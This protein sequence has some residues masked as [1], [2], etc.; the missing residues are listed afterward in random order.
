MAVLSVE[1]TTPGSGYTEPPTI[2]FS[3]ADIDLSG[4]SNPASGTHAAAAA[5]LD[6]DLPENVDPAEVTVYPLSLELNEG[7]SGTYSIVLSEAP[8]DTVVISAVVDPLS[9]VVVEPP[10]VTFTTTDW[11]VPLTL[12]VTANPDDDTEPDPAT[13]IA[14]VPSGGG[15]ENVDVP[16][17]TVT[18]IEI[19]EPVIVAVAVASIVLAAQDVGT[20][21]TECPQVTIGAPDAPN[22]TTATATAVCATHFESYS[23]DDVGSAY[24]N[25]ELQA[26][27][28]NGWTTHTGAFATARYG[29][30]H[31]REPGTTWKV[32]EN[33]SRG[34]KSMYSENVGAPYVYRLD[35][36]SDEHWFVLENRSSGTPR[37]PRV[38]RVH[39]GPLSWGGTTPDLNVEI[40]QS[41]VDL[42][43]RAEVLHDFEFGQWQ[44][45]EDSMAMEYDDRFSDYYA[46]VTIANGAASDR[47]SGYYEFSYELR[48]E[49]VPHLEA[50]TVE[51]LA[52][53]DH[54]WG[55]IIPVGGGKV[56]GYFEAN[57]YDWPFG[58][59]DRD[60]FFFHV[61]EG[62]DFDAV[63]WMESDHED[64]FN[65]TWGSIA[66]RKDGPLE[67][68]EDSY[69][70][71]LINDV[72]FDP[73]NPNTTL[74]RYRLRAGETYKLSMWSSWP[75]TRYDLHV[76][77]VNEPGSDTATA[78]D[79]SITDNS[80]RVR[81]GNIST[82]DDVDYFR[83]VLD[84]ETNVVIRAWG[85]DQDPTAKVN[86]DLNG[87]AELIVHGDL[88][89]S[90]G[91][92]YDTYVGRDR[93][94][95][96]FRGQFAS[97][98][99]DG[100][101]IFETLSAGTYYVQVRGDGSTIGPYTIAVDRHERYPD[102]YK[103][104]AGTQATGVRDY[105]WDCQFGLKNREFPGEDINV[106][107]VWS[108]HDG[109]GVKVLVADT[110]MDINHEDLRDNILVDRNKSYGF[111]GAQIEMKSP[112]EY[113]HGTTVAGVIAARDNE[114]GIRGIAPRAN[115]ISYN[116]LQSASDDNIV[117]ALTDGYD[118]IAVANHSWGSWKSLYAVATTTSA[119][120]GLTHSLNNSYFVDGSPLGTVH[121]KAAGNEYYQQA[122]S[123][124]EEFHSHYGWVVVC[125][126]SDQGTKAWFSEHGS[127]L[128][129]CAPSER[130][131]SMNFK[132][133]ATPR[134]PEDG[135]EQFF[136]RYATPSTNSFNTYK[137]FSGTSV[138]T[139][140]VSGVAALIRDANPN[141]TW[142]D[143]KMILAAT[144]RVNDPIIADERSRWWTHYGYRVPVRDKAN[145]ET[146]AP[147]VKWSGAGRKFG[148]LG[149]DSGSHYRFSH[150]YGFG[151]VDAQ[152]AVEL[153]Q[154]WPGLPEFVEAQYRSEDPPIRINDLGKTHT[155]V[156]GVTSTDRGSS[157]VVASADQ[158]DFIEW[159]AVKAEF[160]SDNFRDLRV[161]LRSPSG[162]ESL[163]SH[164]FDECWDAYGD[165]GSPHSAY[166]D[167][168]GDYGPG[169]DGNR[170]SQDGCQAVPGGT[171]VHNRT[172][173]LG[174]A[175]HL[176]E[177]PCNQIESPN[178][179]CEWTLI[180]SDEEEYGQ[181]TELN[182]WSMMFYGH[183]SGE[184]DNTAIDPPNGDPGD[185]GEGDDGDD[186]DGDDSDDD[187]STDSDGMSGTCVAD[188]TTLCLQ[189]NR[190]KANVLF[191]ATR[192]AFPQRAQL[193]GW[194][195]GS[196][197][198]Y[199]PGVSAFFEDP[200]VD[201]D[202]LSVV[203]KLLDGCDMTG[204]MWFTTAGSVRYR[205]HV[206]LVDTVS[207]EQ[208]TTEN[209]WAQVSNAHVDLGAFAEACASSAGFPA[210]AGARMAKPQGVAMAATA[211]SAG[212]SLHDDKFTV[213]ASYRMGAAIS[214]GA[215]GDA[216]RSTKNSALFRFMGDESFDLLVN[217]VNHCAM[218]KR[219]RVVIAGATIN[220]FSI[221]ITHNESGK[222]REYTRSG[223]LAVWED[224][225]GFM[226]PRSG[227]LNGTRVEGL[228]S[229]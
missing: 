131:E 208:I 119:M 79:L 165:A 227:F 41:P 139:P 97:H 221:T 143:V 169:R 74:L 140:H 25:I 219:Y 50:T 186:S 167:P 61:P 217:V 116:V 83:L 67:E 108:S 63:V 57:Y 45:L 49:H 73:R 187:G 40:W 26:L 118:D 154:V 222:R 192:N 100:F 13:E 78:V 33:G 181:H 91:S 94:T 138:A 124:L 10:S 214:G 20:L 56:E 210:K 102:F 65:G 141:L 170:P 75:P 218:S 5:Y 215:T 220:D 177:S 104:C 195:Q 207:G 178:A 58:F 76:H 153:A 200:F 114:I 190:F 132:D 158:V 34:A 171:S 188:D 189:N 89:N 106:E 21:Y 130:E 99:A 96:Q 201:T 64:G 84:Q 85:G 121:V 223:E 110:G 69:H 120:N 82:V 31:N 72:S 155:D 126:V 37:A 4:A 111:R 147:W 172:L 115:L 101:T 224:R 42:G 44:L 184:D 39:S 12:S 19:D 32:D 81:G 87:E 183:Q 193:A 9:D 174:S 14:H 66:I 197:V 205:Y 209:P 88:R 35:D 7:A 228:C 30:P 134:R 164:P 216:E 122:Y 173:S 150:R 28:A 196:G 137:N 3:G 18:I 123:T 11:D 142:R 151:V 213:T 211:G 145:P 185:E 133:W 161:V 103:D 199:L 46:R 206:I 125:A 17:L 43:D 204:G 51:V 93:F 60:P 36:A 182:A 162:T 191:Y 68:N 24:Y 80:Q 202:D 16:P 156:E 90:D 2:T 168:R 144:A 54:L 163:L 59:V 203:V 71:F 15:Y 136:E 194:T 127:V 149:T 128:W 47:Q 135:I 152:A 107:P 212:V 225:D 1:I 52:N 23:L 226:D 175:R 70:Q 180:V 38:I 6:G 22:E 157:T 109:S 53:D 62:D 98:A 105:L 112:R 148:R 86:Q 92:L 179:P 27:T 166:H 77:E 160:N 95:E 8:S 229:N 29:G 198:F 146:G 48:P 159:L 117:S 176:G 113:S 129:V 55:A